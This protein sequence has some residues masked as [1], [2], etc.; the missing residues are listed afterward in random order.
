MN[1]LCTQIF[2]RF[3]M[4]IVFKSPKR[5]KHTQTANLT[6]QDWMH[7]WPR[8]WSLSSCSCC[9][10]LS[11]TSR[12]SSRSLLM[13]RTSRENRRNARYVWMVGFIDPFDQSIISYPSIYLYIHQAINQPT[14]QPIKH[15]IISIYLSA[16]LWTIY[17]IKG[18]FGSGWPE[19]VCSSC[20]LQPCEAGRWRH[21]RPTGL[22]LQFRNDFCRGFLIPL[23]EFNVRM[24]YVI[25]I[26]YH[27]Y[28]IYNK[29]IYIY[30]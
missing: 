15:I 20:S 24:S 14:K 30:I 5:S 16:C 26:I 7:F 21:D 4:I 12:I 25:Y 3:I 17:N 18:N 22:L 10:W 6:H 2:Y 28:I 8:S 11:N 1:V 29:Y 19:V 9:S 27:R 23:R 13:S